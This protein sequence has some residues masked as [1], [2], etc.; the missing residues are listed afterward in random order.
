[1]LREGPDTNQAPQDPPQDNDHR[2]SQATKSPTK[3]NLNQAV[4]HFDKPEFEVFS[5]SHGDINDGTQ[6]SQ[7]RRD[8][9]ADNLAHKRA[10]RAQTWD[11]V[12]SYGKVALV[13]GAIVLGG[14]V[15]GA[16]K[17]VTE[18]VQSAGANAEPAVSALV[19]GVR[20]VVTGDSDPLANYTGDDADKNIIAGEQ[21]AGSVEAPAPQQEP[22]YDGV[23]TYDA[24]PGLQTLPIAPPA[25]GLAQG[26]PAAE[27]GSVAPG[28][29][30]GGVPAGIR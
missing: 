26:I 7:E 21:D 18:T 6:R 24:D 30:S 19:S 20:D 12:K 13:S 3:S 25:P 5:G 2:R 11:T 29:N 15:S 14:E 27:T 17:A 10:K 4:G 8:A 22:V 23:H 1:M 9:V 28:D 16:R